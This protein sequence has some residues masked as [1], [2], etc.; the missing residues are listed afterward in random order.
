MKALKII[1]Q[2]LLLL[3]L[4]VSGFAYLVGCGVFQ[5]VLSRQYYQDL[6]NEQKILKALSDDIA[7][8][9]PQD[10]LL[11]DV[12]VY[13]PETDTS[14]SRDD[15]IMNALRATIG[16]E[17]FETQLLYSIDYFLAYVDGEAQGIPA[18][19][20]IGGIKEQL[21]TDFILQLQDLSDQEL[22]DMGLTRQNIETAA[23]QFIGAIEL[24]DEI[25][26]HQIFADAEHGPQFHSAVRY[27]RAFKRS[28]SIVPYVVFALL[29]VFLFLLGRISGGLIWFGAGIMASGT[30]A[31]TAIYA[32]KGIVSQAAARGFGS[33]GTVRYASIASLV[34]YTVDRIT[35]MPV[36]FIVLGAAAFA[37]GF[38]VKYLRTRH[39]AGAAPATA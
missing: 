24:P 34:N 28:F 18:V 25:D 9:F 27:I 7:A 23:S 6:F 19:I 39:R 22:A 14:L 31:L 16:S 21:R 10:A 26:L 29:L 2:I 38:V 15:L 35:L 13:L 17:A 3:I 33:G 8:Q 5:S 11:D 1:A 30:L 12:S 36:V 20:G 32:C 37:G 4:I